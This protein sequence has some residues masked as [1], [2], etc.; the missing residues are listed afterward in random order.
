MFLVLLAGAAPI[1]K[2]IVGVNVA[3]TLLASSFQLSSSCAI[4]LQPWP[5]IL[6]FLRQILLHN[7]T[8]TS[9]GEVDVES[10][11]LGLVPD[12][13]LASI[14]IF[15][16]FVVDSIGLADCVWNYFAVQLSAI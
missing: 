7:I 4:D 14:I 9:A 15:L 11:E 8:F 3:L 2:V 13:A 12:R 6:V 1:S 16:G 5:S 10:G